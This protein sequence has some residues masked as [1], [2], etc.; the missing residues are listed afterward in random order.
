MGPMPNGQWDCQPTTELAQLKLPS[1]ITIGK[2]F[3]PG[4]AAGNIS[5]LISYLFL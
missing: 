1:R 3:L 4:G 2:Q 5:F